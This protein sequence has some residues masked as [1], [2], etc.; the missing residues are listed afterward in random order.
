MGPLV[1]FLG[2][3]SSSKETI[4]YSKN[5]AR[6]SAM[7]YSSNYIRIDI[8]HIITDIKLA[9]FLVVTAMYFSTNGYDDKLLVRQ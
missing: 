6:V 9:L 7:N 4:N 8:Q 1:L 3:T 5:C 2:V